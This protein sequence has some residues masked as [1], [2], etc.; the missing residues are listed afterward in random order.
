MPFGDAIGNAKIG[1]FG[2]GGGVR[3]HTAGGT[4]CATGTST[5]RCVKLYW[6]ETF[7]ALDRLKGYTP[8]S[9]MGSL[10]ERKRDA[11]GTE[12]KRNRVYDPKTGRFTQEDPIGFAG[13]VNLYGFAN[14]DPVNFSD[15]FGLCPIPPS[16][17]L[18]VAF[19][20][21]DV[22][23]FAR[24]PSWGTAGGVGLGLASLIPGIPNASALKRG[25]SVRAGSKVSL[26][27]LKA[28]PFG[29]K[30][31]DEIPKGVPRNWSGLDIQDAIVDYRTSI[32]SRKAE[33]AAYDAVGG[34]DPKRR[35]GHARRISQE[36][37]FLRSL[38][39]AWRDRR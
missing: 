20:A 9:Y 16:N 8:Q 15:P 23:D 22:A 39:R 14:G 26:P 7:T 36:E 30:I 33:L 31:A 27:S 10:L 4:A 35:L 34:G 13:G 19:L 37:A 2:D 5:Q 29:L 6:P 11:T 24:N 18:D 12:F 28:S 1:A 21:W 25:I 3:Q 38:E 17:C 32:A